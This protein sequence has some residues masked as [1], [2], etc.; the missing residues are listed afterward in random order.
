MFALFVTKNLPQLQGW[1]ERVAEKDPQAATRLVLDAA[2]YHVPKLA[3]TE[4]TGEGGGPVRVAAV[5][6]EL[7][8]ETTVVDLGRH[9]AA[10]LDSGQ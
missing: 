1:I 9:E 6:D 4:L 10:R 2:E 7:H 5:V 3:R 8:Q